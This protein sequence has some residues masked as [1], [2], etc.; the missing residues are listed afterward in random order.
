M[1]NHMSTLNAA[2]TNRTLRISNFIA[3]A[4]ALV[5]V[6]FVAA[7]GSSSKVK[8]IS[9]IPGKPEVYFD[10]SACF[11]ACPAY[12]LVMRGDGTARYTGK[13]NVEMLGIF[14]AVIDAD[15]MQSLLSAFEETKFSAMDDI[16]DDN[17]TD[18]ATRTVRL[19]RFDSSK[20]VTDRFNTPAELRRLENTI[21]SIAG[22]LSW[23][24][25]ADLPKE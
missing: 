7:C 10:R 13:S 5:A 21:D 19:R 2:S 1:K 9:D 6:L 16:Y 8:S 15:R 17:V 20:T 25:V 12:T 14:E 18:V 22:T 11:G 24:K 3:M 4:A 23:K